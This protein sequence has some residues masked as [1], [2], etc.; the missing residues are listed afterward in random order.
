MEIHPNAARTQ[1]HWDAIATGDLTAALDDIADDVV[2]IHGPGAGPFA[3][4]SEGKVHGFELG[5][6]FA[7]VF[8]DS[9]AQRGQC[10]YADDRCSVTMVHET[11]TAGDGARFDNHALWITR[12]GHDG[13]ADFIW[14]VDL[15]DEAMHSFWD[16]RATMPER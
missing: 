12:F 11:G 7:E 9:F 6:L 14:T 5:L 3:G 1:S 13:K 10:V 4:R 15:D 8:G 2:M 16:S